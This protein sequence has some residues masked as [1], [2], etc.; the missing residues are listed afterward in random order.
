MSIVFDAGALIALER[1]DRR[2]WAAVQLAA[3]ESEDVLVPSTVL[4][5]VWRGKP[6]QAGLASV[7]VHC[8]IAPFDSI[9]RDIGELCGLTRTSDICDAH[10]ALAAAGREAVFT[11]DPGDIRRLL[12]A[13]DETKVRIVR[14]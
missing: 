12:A 1:N 13:L 6:K 11:S 4:A 3:L 9:A 5:Q 7:L 8:V 10:V 14:C 2:L